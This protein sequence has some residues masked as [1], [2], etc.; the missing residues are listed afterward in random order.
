MRRTMRGTVNVAAEPAASDSDRRRRTLMAIGLAAAYLAASTIGFLVTAAAL[1]NVDSQT[2]A[3]LVLAVMTTALL[4]YLA[5]ARLWQQAGLRASD[6]HT[7]WVLL[8][9]PLVLVLIPLLGGVR[10]I[11]SGALAILVVGYALTG[12]TEETWFRGLVLD[13]LRPAGATRAVLLAALLFG[14]V[15]LGNVFIRPSVALVVAQ[16][17]GAF[18]FGVAYGALRLHLASIWPL[19][20]L[21]GLHDLL[22]HVG[23][24]PLVPVDV[25]QDVILLAYGVYLLRR[26]EFANVQ[27]AETQLQPAN[28]P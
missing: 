17:V 15:H 11:T 1:P 21:H 8:L 16:A 9:L 24:L 20:A 10:S 2:R 14:L 19:I 25:F 3:L 5:G 26:A 18:C 23:G 13:R 22:L 4:A 6:R 27:V 28:R 12:F 7:P